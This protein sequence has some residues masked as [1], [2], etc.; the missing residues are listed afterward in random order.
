MKA[1]LKVVLLVLV[2]LFALPAAA[3]TPVFEKRFG[4]ASASCQRTPKTRVLVCVV[5]YMRQPYLGIQ[6]GSEADPESVAITAGARREPGSELTIRVD[7]H[8]VHN[9]TRD[10]FFDYEAVSM[11]TEIEHG[12]QITVRFE[13]EDSDVK[14]A[15]TFSLAD[16]NAALR[17]VENFREGQADE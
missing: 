7:N 6:L 17:A 1:A 5:V 12:G 2:M 15:D 14:T 4:H 9:T 10:G 8:A 16:I 13:S 3:Q 11:L